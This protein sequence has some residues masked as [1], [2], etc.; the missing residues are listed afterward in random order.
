MTFSG[1]T[2]AQPS[3]EVRL[4]GIMLN[5]DTSFRS[6]I[7]NIKKKMYMAANIPFR[8]RDMG[9]S[10]HNIVAAYKMFLSC[11]VEYALPAYGSLLN[12]AQVNEIE[13]TQRR[14]IMMMTGWNLNYETI[15]KQ[16]NIMQFDEL[17]KIRTMNFA[18]KNYINGSI[19]DWFEKYD[20]KYNMRHSNLVK[21]PKCNNTKQ[22]NAPITVFAKKI[23]L[24]NTKIKFIEKEIKS[25]KENKNKIKSNSNVI[26]NFLQKFKNESNENKNIYKLWMYKKS[27]V[28]I[29]V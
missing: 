29:N 19:S 4:L 10:Y 3:D 14:I 13:K 15:R 25:L 20:N 26:C 18:Y 2:P 9:A 16:Y 21:V 7:A 22:L 12:K 23:N 28:Q 11:H 6:Q 27:L 8:M 17:I 1:E 5:S 24:V